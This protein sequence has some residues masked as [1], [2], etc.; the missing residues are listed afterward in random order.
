MIKKSYP[1][2][3]KVI[4]GSALHC[5]ITTIQT[6]T[7][8]STNLRRLEPRWYRNLRLWLQYSRLSLTE[9]MVIWSNLKIYPPWADNSITSIII[10][11]KTSTKIVMTSQRGQTFM[12]MTKIINNRQWL[13]HVAVPIH[14]L[15]TNS[16]KE[17]KC[18]LRLVF[19]NHPRCWCNDLRETS[20][21]QM[22]K[23][24][25]LHIIF[26]QLSH[27]IRIWWMT[28]YKDLK[29][30]SIRHHQLLPPPAS[31]QWSSSQDQF[32]SKLNVRL[33]TSGL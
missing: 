32:I 10:V 27:S 3:K 2:L 4:S 24:P 33:N 31:L 21:S 1:Y 16:T 22:K 6:Q 29:M 18:F 7:L 28:T 17:L 9:Q 23:W 12:D 20:T 11:I 15:P 26:I 25:I 30:I 5:S 8:K 14:W 13:A 19:Q